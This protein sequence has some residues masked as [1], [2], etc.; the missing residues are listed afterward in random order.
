MA[1]AHAVQLAPNVWRIPLV[2]DFVNGFILRDDDSA[3]G[4]AADSCHR[5]GRPA[6]PD[7]EESS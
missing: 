5:S 3:V 7:H 2:R 1:S 4:A 6:R